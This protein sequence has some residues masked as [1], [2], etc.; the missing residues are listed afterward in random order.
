MTDVIISEV[1]PKWSQGPGR[2]PDAEVL[3]LERVL[4]VPQVL[5]KSY[6]KQRTDNATEIGE[7]LCA[8]RDDTIA[9]RPI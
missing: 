9:E 2:M 6:H 3:G 5:H 1:R 8:P 7:D 4:L